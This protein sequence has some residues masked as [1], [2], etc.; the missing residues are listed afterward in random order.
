MKPCFQKRAIALDRD[1]FTAL[2]NHGQTFLRKCGL[3]KYSFTK[4]HNQYRKIKP[5]HLQSMGLW[6][7]YFLGVQGFILLEFVS[8]RDKAKKDQNPDLA[9]YNSKQFY[10]TIQFYKTNRAG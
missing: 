2:F 9:L 7:K 3:L 4:L 8:L 6:V 1:S 5:H 10:K